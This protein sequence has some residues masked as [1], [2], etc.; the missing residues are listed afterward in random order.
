MRRRLDRSTVIGFAL[1][2]ISAVI[3]WLANRD[4]DA[5]RGDFFYLADAFLH[6]RTWLS[7]VI[8]S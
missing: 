1:V 2:A 6:G 7:V 3:Y 8:R 4:F 5:Y